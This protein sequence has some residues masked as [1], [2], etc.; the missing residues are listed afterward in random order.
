ML[1]VGERYSESLP[2]KIHAK[3]QLVYFI[4]SIFQTVLSFKS[5]SKCKTL[6]VAIAKIMVHRF[7]IF[8]KNKHLSLFC[9]YQYVKVCLLILFIGKQRLVLRR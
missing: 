5:L 1:L 4:N 6:P 3:G 2:L 7:L 8:A 9:T